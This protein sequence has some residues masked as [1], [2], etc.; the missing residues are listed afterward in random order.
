[1]QEFAQNPD[2]ISAFAPELVLRDVPGKS[3]QRPR[4]SE[5]FRRSAFFGALLDAV[6]DEVVR[7]A[8]PPS[9]LVLLPEG[10]LTSRV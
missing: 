7:V 3:V 10:S 4:Q 9:L 5:R 6:R 8:F 2:E 1:M